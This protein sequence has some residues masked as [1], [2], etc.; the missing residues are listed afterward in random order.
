MRIPGGKIAVPNLPTGFTPRP[1]L[2][3]RLDR[4]GA[5]ELVVV[6]APPGYGKTALL[7]DWLRSPHAPPS[8][9]VSVD[10]G[11]DAPRLRAA[12]LAAL[13]AVPGLPADSPL[14]EIGSPGRGDLPG[15]NLI[16]ELAAGVDATRP[17]IRVVLDD[18]HE[19]TDPEAL[20]DLARL[21]RRRP[22]G[23]CLVLSGRMDPPLPLPRMRLEGRVHELRAEDL[24]FDVGATAALLHAS[25][26]DIAPEQVAVL[27]ARTGGWAAGLRLAVLALRGRD[28]PQAFIAQFSGN[29]SSVAGY[30]TDEVMAV[31]PDEVRQFLR[32]CSVCTQLPAGLAVALT[33]RADAERMLDELTRVT[34]LVE[35]AEP[36]TYRMHTLLRTYLVTELER[37]FPALHRRAD[38]A[39]ARWWLAADE[40]EHALRHAERTGEPEPVLDILRESGV[41]LIA[42]G[43]LAAVRR[44]L[45]ACGPAT[46][47]TDPWPSLVAALLHDAENAR[48][49]AAEALA[50]AVRGWPRDTDPVLDVLRASVERLVTGR[51]QD[52][53][54]DPPVSVPPELEA[55]R[56]MSEAAV[57]DPVIGVQAGV[58]VRTRLDEAARLAREHGFPY[59]EV[60]TL[61]ML[62]AFEAAR[63]G[64]GAMTA[65]AS[66]ALAAAEGESEG[67]RPADRTAGPAALIAYGDLLAGDAAA[68]L[69]RTEDVLATEAA[70]APRTEVALRVVHRAACADLGEHARGGGRWLV[71]FD[72][73]DA[74]APLLAALAVLEH[75]AVLAQRGPG[76]AAETAEWLARRVGKVGELLLMDAWA[77]LQA[78]RFDAARTAVGA[79]ADGSLGALVP[80]TP[81]E[82]HL[83]RTEAALRQ[84]D[85]GT[86]RV[87]LAAAFAGGAAFG[88]VRPFLLAG[89][90]TRGLLVSDPPA[91]TDARFAGRVAAA[92]SRARVDVPAAL[93]ERELAVLTLLPSLL[94]AREIADELMV[95]VNTVKSHIRSI[96]AKL[97]VSTRRDAIRRAQE[98]DLFP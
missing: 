62:A 91:G 47:T 18:V 87:E 8:A 78:G 61:S 32:T 28:D 4:V 38:T 12:L 96:Y 17:A 88:V 14:H 56:R 97:G 60:R 1:H 48:S 53:P 3:R 51:A 55:L 84:G 79:L 34:A 6:T 66:A 52:P 29:E 86:A 22:R 33:G 15:R 10:A 13:R 43:R 2:L 59:F 27:Q 63:G 85:L 19:L 68:A 46:R 39:A 44:A 35:L 75:R 57:I 49:A 25:G 64:Y 89:A 65:A 23:L 98:L 30:L 94:S 76:P 74:P 37:H 50:R 95:S 24:R 80:Y 45:D 5:G 92:L 9:W 26:I 69:A 31:L 42:T 7:A 21:V 73:V 58:A 67:E 36:R 90:M 83:V 40:P 54:S 82:V 71:E 11:D 70:L 16:D 72:D 41:R 81:V 77:H 93:S 20:R